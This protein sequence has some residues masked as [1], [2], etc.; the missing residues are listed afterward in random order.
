[1]KKNTLKYS[2]TITRR[3]FQAAAL[4]ALGGVSGCGAGAKEARAKDDPM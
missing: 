4:A 2:E 3:T 1:M